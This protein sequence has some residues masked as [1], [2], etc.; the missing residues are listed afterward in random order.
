MRILSVRIDS[1]QHRFIRFSNPLQLKL[2]ILGEAATM[3]ITVTVVL[4]ITAILAVVLRLYCR[5]LQNQPLGGD[6]YCV[7]IALVEFGDL[8]LWLPH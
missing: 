2:N 8:S 6:D 5:K 3:I 1:E 4:G 7:L